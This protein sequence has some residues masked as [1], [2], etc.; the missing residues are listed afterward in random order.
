[1]G[2]QR[3]TEN[4]KTM[5]KVE[6]YHGSYKLQQNQVKMVWLQRFDHLMK[7]VD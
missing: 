7:C 2:I 6:D 5:F 3:M 1:M 4:K